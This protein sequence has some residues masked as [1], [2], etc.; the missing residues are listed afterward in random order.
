M[1]R[2]AHINNSS[3]GGRLP[4]GHGI[5]GIK[6]RIMELR[7]PLCGPAEQPLDAVL[8]RCNTFHFIS[9]HFIKSSLNPHAFFEL[10]GDVHMDPNRMVWLLES[11]SPGN[12]AIDRVNDLCLTISLECR[13]R[14]GC[15]LVV[16]PFDECCRLCQEAFPD[17]GSKPTSCAGA[18]GHLTTGR[19]LLGRESMTKL[20]L[21][22][23][24]AHDVRNRV[25]A[26]RNSSSTAGLAFLGGELGAGD[27]PRG[28]P[29]NRLSRSHTPSLGLSSA[30]FVSGPQSRGVPVARC[31]QRQSRELGKEVIVACHGVH[32]LEDMGG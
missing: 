9:F 2:E 25:A 15:E 13:V 4:A 6:A 20:G 11:K 18:K 5:G 29:P 7:L 3:D 16:D 23:I 19:T 26:V 27:S 24:R 32:F 8:R 30:A 12:L 28:G 10:P 17:F 1:G 14:D 31:V 22:D 21:V